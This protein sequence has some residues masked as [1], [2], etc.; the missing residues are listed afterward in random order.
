MSTSQHNDH[1]KLESIM[2]L[3][4]HALILFHNRNFQSSYCVFTC[5]LSKLRSIYERKSNNRRAESRKIGETNDYSRNESN[6]CIESV[7]RLPTTNQDI[8]VLHAIPQDNITC[9]MEASS[10]ITDATYVRPRNC[11]EL[12]IFTG[13]FCLRKL[14]SVVPETHCEVILDLITAVV[15]CNIGL[16]SHLIGIQNGMFKAMA[17]EVR[18]YYERSYRILQITHDQ[19]DY[20]CNLTEQNQQYLEILSLIHMSLCLNI[21]EIR[22]SSSFVHASVEDKVTTEKLRYTIKVI[23]DSLLTH[24][25]CGGTWNAVTINDIYFFYQWLVMARFIDDCSIAPA[26]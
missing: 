7:K 5:I 3:H 11:Q 12:D 2:S 24:K 20:S 9:S 18:S 19:S 21:S 14:V 16:T 25:A 26:A 1:N 4:E 6:F 17:K 8:V 10:S 15:L 13:A 23:V 22:S